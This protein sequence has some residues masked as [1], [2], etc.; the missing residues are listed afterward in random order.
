MSNPPPDLWTGD[1][2]GVQQSSP[3]G[4]YY[5]SPIRSYYQVLT[6]TTTPT[7]ELSIDSCMDTFFRIFTFQINHFLICLYIY[8]L[9]QLVSYMYF[10]YIYG[11]ILCYQHFQYLRKLN[12]YSIREKQNFKLIQKNYNSMFPHRFPTEI[13]IFFFDY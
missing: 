5:L 11:F 12:L 10:M 13:I 7:S 8:Y 1:V 2:R 4:N 3:S 6:T 9:Y